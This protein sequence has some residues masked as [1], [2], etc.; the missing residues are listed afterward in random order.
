MPRTRR[1]P[2][3]ATPPSC[4]AIGVPHPAT[5]GRDELLR[6]CTL[7]AVRR[8]GP[9][10]QHRNR[11][12]TG[13]QIAHR[14]SGIIAEANERRER[15]VN[16]DQA[17]RRLRVR[18]AL[19]VRASHADFPSPRWLARLH[20]TR[21][22]VAEGHWEFPAILAEVLDWIAPAAGD[23]ASVSPSLRCS[24]TQIVRLISRV[25]AALQRVN[26]WRA[27]WGAAPLRSRK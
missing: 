2:S 8:G 3:P 26:Q 14:P 21:I 16:L 7:S 9:G 4:A 19:D 20:G 18:L 12:A 22:D 11:N 10:G 17:I 24:P 13:V 6:Q 1:T 5:L 23:L 15:S 27:Q 25:P